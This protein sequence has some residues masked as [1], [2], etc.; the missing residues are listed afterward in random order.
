MSNVWIGPIFAGL[1]GT[2]V[3]TVLVSLPRLLGMKSA[4]MVSAL[5]ALVSREKTPGRAFL[6]GLLVHYLVGLLFAALYLVGFRAFGFPF[7]PITGAF[8]GVLHG[9]L[10]MMVVEMIVFRRLPR[11]QDAHAL[12][13]EARIA[14]ALQFVGHILYGAI[15]AWV[16]GLPVPLGGS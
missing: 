10:A 1:L 11:G 13:N 5:G 15:V 16:Y 2:T 7:N 4:D 9:G 3:L 8:V 12:D 6:P 14:A